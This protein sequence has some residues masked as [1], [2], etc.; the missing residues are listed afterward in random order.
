M[1]PI[2]QLLCRSDVEELHK[3]HQY[4]SHDFSKVFGCWHRL[5]WS[6]WSKQLIISLHAVLQAVLDLPPRVMNWHWQDF[7]QLTGKANA[8]KWIQQTLKPVHIA[9]QGL[10]PTTDDTSGQDDTCSS[11]FVKSYSC[12]ISWP[13]LIPGMYLHIEAE[14][15]AVHH[16]KRRESWRN[17]WILCDVFRVGHTDWTSFE[18]SMAVN[19]GLYSSGT[20]QQRDC[21]AQKRAYARSISQFLSML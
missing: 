19:V 15:A 1:L 6:P 20:C 5:S 13:H 11:L 21:S 16:L 9:V 18:L 7:F 8:M 10:Q 12:W 3:I 4:D 2:Y 17:A 14:G